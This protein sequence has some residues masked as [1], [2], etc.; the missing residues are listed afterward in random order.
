[1]I[2]EAKEQ[3]RITPD[4]VILTVGGGGLLAGVLEGMHKVGW[5][6]VPLL[7][8]E[9]Y[10]ADSFAS[11]VNAGKIVSLPGIAR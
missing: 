7:A 1:M 2:V 6:D 10:G 9:T 11:A 5:A 8:V 3:M 4:V